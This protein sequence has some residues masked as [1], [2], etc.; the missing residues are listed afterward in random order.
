MRTDTRLA[1][2]AALG[3]GAIAATGPSA[4]AEPAWNGSY[5]ADGACHC[6][7]ALDPGV[8][9]REVD[10]PVGRRSVARVCEAVGAGPGLSF[11]GGEW[12]RTV[13]PDTQCGHGPFASG[14]ELLDPECAGTRRPGEADCRPV[15]PTWDLASAFVA[16]AAARA[17]PAEATIGAGGAAGDAHASDIEIVEIDGRSWR[18]APAGTPRTGGR[19]GSR[20][21]LDGELWLEA[22]DPRFAAADEA[23]ERERRAALRRQAAVREVEYREAPPATPA[24]ASTRAPV[25]SAATSSDGRRWEEAPAESFDPEFVAA[26]DGREPTPDADEGALAA[27]P[28]RRWEEAPAE[29]FESGFRAG[30]GPVA[31][32]DDPAGRGE[33]DALPLAAALPAP[34]PDDVRA[35]P[36]AAG[37]E[38]VV[39]ADRA[40]SPEAPAAVDES[41]GAV[42]ATAPGDGAAESAAPRSALRLPVDARGSSDEYG[43][44]E[45]MPMSYDFGGAGI[46]F[47][48]SGEARRRFHFLVRAGAAESYR[49]IALGAGVHVTPPEAD[50]LTFA[51]TA[52][53]EYGAFDLT[54]TD[55]NGDPLRDVTDDDAGAFVSL[56]T[57]LVVN[58]RFELAG[59]VGYSSFH[60]GDPHGFGGAF[61]HVNRRFDLMSRFEVGDNDQLGIGLRYYY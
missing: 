20:I 23:A 3:C 48:A 43:Y 42:A 19:P 9:A 51:V 12:S 16:P 28:E 38:A 8:A 1:V 34:A 60:E 15:G 41:A 47:E 6:T 10:T 5:A 40:P 53:V 11:E 21:V 22:D 30:D 18:R 36:D 29:S 49:E 46:G 35:V 26:P 13:Y 7:G 37:A 27:A 57:R 25:A 14:V 2:L 45:A 33:D 52:G 44:V 4:A 17:R 24:P 61:F 59:G 31:R 58:P 54:A 32:A 39:D 55:A 56:S 50:R